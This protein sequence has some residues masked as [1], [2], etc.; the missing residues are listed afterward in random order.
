MDGPFAFRFIYT[1]SQVIGLPN[2]IGHSMDF[3][4]RLLKALS[5]NL[6]FIFLISRDEIPLDQNI[7]T[8]FKT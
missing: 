2:S 5:F 7:E 8:K 6:L 1:T 3:R 4:W